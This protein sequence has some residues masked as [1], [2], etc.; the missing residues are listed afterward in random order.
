MRREQSIGGGV[1][2]IGL[3][4]L[5]FTVCEELQLAKLCGVDAVI[6]T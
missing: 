3:V 4:G 6:S 5:S 1:I 2:V